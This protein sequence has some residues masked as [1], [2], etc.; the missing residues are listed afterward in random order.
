MKRGR[1]WLATKYIVSEEHAFVYFVVPKVACSSMKTALLP[2]FPDLDHTPGFE[3]EARDS[4]FAYRVH[5]LFDRSIHQVDKRRLLDRIRESYRSFYKFAF[6]R[7]PWDRLLSC[8]SQKLAPSGA[9]QGLG[10][11][12]W[13]GERLWVGMGFTEFAETV[14]RI[15]DEKA[16]PHFRSQHIVVCGNGPKKRVL[17]DFVG[18]FEN[19]EE[20]FA[21]VA[22]KIGGDICHTS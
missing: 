18:H 14:C 7:N 16:E 10:R 5:G 9:R 1:N 15:P 20:D 2:L 17:T 13:G 12:D 22:E 4:G 11:E 6:V 21:L 3:S 8:W 19:L